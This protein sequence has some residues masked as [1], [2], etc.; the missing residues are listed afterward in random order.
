MIF[1]IGK[2]TKLPS[3]SHI[4]HL[5][6]HNLLRTSNNIIHLPHPKHLILRFQLLRHTLFL[7]HLFHNPVQHLIAFLVSLMHFIFS[8]T[9]FLSCSVS[10]SP[11]LS[12]QTCHALLSPEFLKYIQVPLGASGW[13]VWN[14]FHQE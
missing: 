10:V 2:V 7:L 6:H 5:P 1:Q 9:N 8:A 12:F 4:H 13:L 14:F 3:P 11:S